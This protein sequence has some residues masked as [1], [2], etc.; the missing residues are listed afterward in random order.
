MAGEHEAQ[1]YPAEG[2]DVKGIRAPRR[3]DGRDV[4]TRGTQPSR[5]TTLAP[6]NGAVAFRDDK[7]GIARGKRVALSIGVWRD[8]GLLRRPQPGD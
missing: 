3:L 7:K 4:P 8:L 2:K 6:T 1:L 5:D